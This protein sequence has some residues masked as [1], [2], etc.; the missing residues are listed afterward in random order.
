MKC[1]L[2]HTKKQE[3]QQLRDKIFNRKRFRDD[4]DVRTNRVLKITMLIILKLL[5]G[6]MTAFP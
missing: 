6:K 5:T 3:K 2:I 1:Y 4:Q